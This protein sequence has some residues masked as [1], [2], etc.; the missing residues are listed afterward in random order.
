MSTLPV[1]AMSGKLTKADD[2]RVRSSSASWWFFNLILAGLCSAFYSAGCLWTPGSRMAGAG[3]GR[4][5]F[6][7]L[8]AAL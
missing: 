6:V 3:Q 4:A 5:P 8:S 2:G 7:T 1:T